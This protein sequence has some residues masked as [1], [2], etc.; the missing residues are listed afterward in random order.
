MRRSFPGNIDG[1][2]GQFKLGKSVKIGIRTIIRFAFAI[3]ASDRALGSPV[4]CGQITLCT[5]PSYV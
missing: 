3:H 4:V 2:Y 1:G 5:H